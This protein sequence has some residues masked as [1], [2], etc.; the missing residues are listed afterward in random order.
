M[1]IHHVAIWTKDLEI[2]SRFY[3]KYFGAKKGKMYENSIKGFSSYFLKFEGG[4][5]LE[6]MK[7]VRIPEI[8][9]N[10]NDQ[11][12]GIIH[13]AISVGSKEDVDRKTLE[14]EKDG[15]LVVSKPRWTGDGYYE[16]CIFD[17]EN[18]RIEITI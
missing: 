18:N 9:N 12:L 3:E 1:N 17:P 8:K 7:M 15:Y 4:S 2:L 6:L 5:S 11:Y 13:L 10:I 16:S 14:I